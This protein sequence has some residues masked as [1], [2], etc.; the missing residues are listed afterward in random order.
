MAEGNERV[1]VWGCLAGQDGDVGLFGRVRTASLFVWSCEEVDF[2]L[3]PS[4]SLE[5]P[6]RN[7]AQF[8][9]ADSAGVRFGSNE[10]NRRSESSFN[11][12]Y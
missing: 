4:W 9:F 6:K 11:V 8:V 1:A 10:Q 5:F 3:A 2:A 7:C 12:E